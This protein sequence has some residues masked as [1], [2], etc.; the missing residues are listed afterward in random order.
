MPQGITL[1]SLSEIFLSVTGHA[2]TQGSLQL[3]ERLEILRYIDKEFVR[4]VRPLPAEKSGFKYTPRSPLDETKLNQAISGH[5]RAASPGDTVQITDIRFEPDAIVI[6]I[7][8]GAKQ[9]FRL[10]DHLHA[11]ISGGGQST[12]TPGPDNAPP[13]STPG[14]PGAG[15]GPMPGPPAG[16]DD[17]PT[18]PQSTPQPVRP[19]PTGL[20]NRVGAT[21]V[22]D[23]GHALPDM[24]PDDLKRDLSAFLS[25]SAQTS[26]AV[27]W[28]DTLPPEFREA[29][30]DH[31]ALAGMNA[32]MV[33][34][35]L[36][37]PDKKVRETND[38]GD[39]TEDWIYGRPP[40]KTVFVTFLN[41]KVTRV[42]Q[43]P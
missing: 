37:R 29:I 34:A 25:F 16:P 32:D 24:G 5:G 10:F 40:G 1:P 36:G 14:G 8:G 19:P 9:H 39:E 26:A 31:H 22:L 43:F 35:A 13:P 4:V 3:Q 41:S 18:I 38:A 15:P 21:L 12:S 11:G 23:Y 6:E 30:K 42:E 33:I 27:S 7:N 2:A 20:P 17:T 28:V